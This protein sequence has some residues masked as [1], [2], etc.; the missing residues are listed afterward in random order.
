VLEFKEIQIWLSS[1]RHICARTSKAIAL[2]AVSPPVEVMP[3]DLLQSTF[4][5]RLREHLA[6]GNHVR[7][8]GIAMPPRAPGPKVRDSNDGPDCPSTPRRNLNMRRAANLSDPQRGKVLGGQKPQRQ[9][10]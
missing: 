10:E 7:S 5:K 6:E 8:A 2:Q 9:S 4:L 3:S 1:N